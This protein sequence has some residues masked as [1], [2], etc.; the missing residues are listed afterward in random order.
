MSDGWGKSTK[1]SA[2]TCVEVKRDGDDYLVRSSEHP[3]REPLR[4][5]A[6]EWAAFVLGV[7]GGEFRS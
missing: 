2:A 7:E 5:T 3:E 1:C 6:E 4:F